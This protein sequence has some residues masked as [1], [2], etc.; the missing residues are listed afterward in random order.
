MK[1]VRS[2][3]S[4]R[5]RQSTKKEANW[6]FAYICSWGNVHHEPTGKRKNGST[7][8]PISNRLCTYSKFIFPDITEISRKYHWNITGIKSVPYELWWQVKKSTGYF[9]TNF[10]KIIT[11]ELHISYFIHNRPAFQCMLSDS[12]QVSM[13]TR[14]K[15]LRLVRKLLSLGNCFGCPGYAD[16]YAT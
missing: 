4:V 7:G 15:H 3:L 11:Q 10:D 13:Y 1:N 16:R 8:A 5:Q 2:A 9:I 6:M 12:P 14:I